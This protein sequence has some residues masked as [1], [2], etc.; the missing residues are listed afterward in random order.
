MSLSPE[1][2]PAQRTV[3]GYFYRQRGSTGHWE[4]D[5]VDCRAAEIV[6]Q[7]TPLGPRLAD[8]NEKMVCEVHIEV[9]AGDDRAVLIGCHRAAADAEFLKNRPDHIILA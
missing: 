8:N 7:S 1:N 5:K 3:I 2:T 9:N 4:C 6:E